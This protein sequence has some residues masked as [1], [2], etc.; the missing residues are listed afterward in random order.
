MRFI[1]SADTRRNNDFTAAPSFAGNSGFLCKTFS[2]SMYQ[3]SMTEA[4]SDF[5]ASCSA[6]GSFA[7][8]LVVLRTRFVF[9]AETAVDGLRG[10]GTGKTSSGVL[11]GSGWA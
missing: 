10:V 8:D 4:W 5:A 11:E 1:S 9:D 3:N 7:L 6:A 2:Y